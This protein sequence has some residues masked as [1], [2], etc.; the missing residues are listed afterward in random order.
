MNRGNYS[1]EEIWE[2]I[3]EIYVGENCYKN[4]INFRVILNLE[5]ININNRK[6]FWNCC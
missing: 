4:E 5:L 6:D 1:W 2:K 3:K